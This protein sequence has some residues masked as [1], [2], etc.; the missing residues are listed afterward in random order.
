MISTRTVAAAVLTAGL[1]GAAFAQSHTQGHGKM[2]VDPAAMQQ[3]IKDSVPKPT[4]RPRRKS[5][6]K[7]TWP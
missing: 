6:K 7:P 4:T 2:P 1:A 3:M 5:S